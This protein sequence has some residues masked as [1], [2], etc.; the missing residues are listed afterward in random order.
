[1]PD[2]FYK[3]INNMMLPE[4][5]STWCAHSSN[6]LGDDILDLVDEYASRQDLEKGGT[7]GGSDTDI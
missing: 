7:T 3:D 1:M 6:L 4:R 5:H 2:Y